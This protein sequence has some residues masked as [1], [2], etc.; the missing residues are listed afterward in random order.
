VQDPGLQSGVLV[1]QPLGVSREQRQ[2]LIA[3]FM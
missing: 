3:E 1:K 2:R